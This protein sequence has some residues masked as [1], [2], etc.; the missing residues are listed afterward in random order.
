MIFFKSMVII[1]VFKYLCISRIRLQIFSRLMSHTEQ[2]L[3]TGYLLT[4]RYP[5]RALKNHVQLQVV[6]SEFMIY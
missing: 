5:T 3:L 4:L 1:R 6:G 2:V